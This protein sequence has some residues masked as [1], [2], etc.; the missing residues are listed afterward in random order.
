MSD[1]G[2]AG[3][4]PMVN[5]PLADHDMQ[6]KARRRALFV[7][8]ESP[9]PMMGGGALRAASLLEY[10]ARGYSVDVVVFRQPDSEVAFPS[11]RVDRVLTIDLPRHSKNQAIRFLRNGQR[12]LRRNPPLVDRFAGFGSQIAAFVKNRPAYDVAVVEH[13]WCAPYWEQIGPR[14]SRTILDLHN[15]E[16]A[17]HLGCGKVAGWPHSVAH[18]IFHRAAL[19]LER[20]WLPRYSALL[21]ASPADA[22]RV[23]RIAP[24]SR[25]AIYPNT[26]PF[27]DLPT[28]KEQHIIVFS[29]T[30]E[31]EP[32]RA[33]VRYFTSEIWPAL[34]RRWPNLK[35]LLVGRD[36]EAV[37]QY[38][39][40]V[41]EIECTGRVD[42]ALSHLAAAKVAVVPILSGSGTRLKIIEAWAAGT[43][44][45]STS[46]G[47]EGLP[48]R[49]GENI[50][51][52]DDPESFIRAVSR[53][54]E[55][56][57]ERGCIGRA[58]RDQ[59]ERELTWSVAW[60]ML[61]R[62]FDSLVKS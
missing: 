23:A 20:Q 19:D 50:L 1:V 31:Y 22:Q 6:A 4:L 43:A 10:L 45:V 37:R 34:R 57:T 26:I 9:Y 49:E 5:R 8:P 60:E 48:A 40:D 3:S 18:G 54:L 51:I 36:P 58:G 44:V 17:W 59:Y 24:K 56:A 55:S 30:L 28:R 12:V 2:Q 25:V 11:G 62:E 33:A 27:V 32:N 47:A 14:C 61:D 41:P 7:A 35:W 42:D 16:S 29:G 21:A 46:L 39:G 13:F 53:L 15:I 52:A 38:V